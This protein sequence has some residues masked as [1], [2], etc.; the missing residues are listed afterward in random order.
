M[1]G[2]MRYTRRRRLF[3]RIRIPL[4]LAGAAG[5]W[6]ITGARWGA[7]GA[8]SGVAAACLA[9]AVFCV[10]RAAADA[11]ARL[12]PE[13]IAAMRAHA[14][15]W[16]SEAER[17]PAG[18]PVPGGVLPGWNWVPPSGIR[19]RLDRVPAWVRLWYRTPFADRYAYAWMWRHGGWDVLPPGAD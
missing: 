10:R 11:R 1:P 15:R 6:A 7:V 9:E 3:W 14:R 13:R 12:T 19:E 4:W 18:W 17:S 8:A 16:D 2:R 5:G